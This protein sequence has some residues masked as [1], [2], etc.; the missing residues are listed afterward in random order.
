[1]RK[2]E[3]TIEIVEQMVDAIPEYQTIAFNYFVQKKLEV[4]KAYENF[5]RVWHGKELVLDGL[6]YLPKVLEVYNA[7]TTPPEETVKLDN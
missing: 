3:L 7:I 6:E 5:F 4:N 1:M 2:D